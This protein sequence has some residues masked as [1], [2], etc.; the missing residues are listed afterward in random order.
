M[1]KDTLLQAVQNDEAEFVEEE[2]VQDDLFE[3]HFKF[4]GTL[5]SISAHGNERWL[6]DDSDFITIKGD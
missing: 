3:L 2:H 5:F 4:E 6:M 1:E